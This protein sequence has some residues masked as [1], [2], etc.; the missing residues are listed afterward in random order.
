[1]TFILAFFQS[2]I[3]QYLTIRFEN[4]YNFF[5]D[6]N[7]KSHAIHT[8]P[9]PRVGGIG[10]FL[11]FAISMMIL[12]PQYWWLVVGG[13]VIFGFGLYEDWHG[14]TRKEFRLGAMA[15]GTYIAIYFGGYVADNSEFFILP[16]AAAAV[17]TIFAV[18][19]TSSAI[20]FIDGLNGLAGGLSGSVLIFFLGLAYWYGDF[21]L[22][23]VIAIL[24]GA[25]GGFFLWNYPK[26]K[27]FLGDGGAYFLGSM[28]A[29]IAIILAARHDEISLWYAC[30]ALLYPVIE[31]FVTIDRRINRKRKY[32]TPFFEA[33]RVHLHTLKFRRRTKDN[34]AATRR[35]LLFNFYINL[36]AVV[37][38]QSVPALIIV[39]I[40]AYIA[41]SV[42]YKKIIRFGYPKKNRC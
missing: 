28:L 33:E 4:K 15:V 11:A 37:F 38:H 36:A 16:Y 25:I 1:M 40:L 6:C 34:A 19:G 3:Y 31:T 13:A 30:I 5:V 42:K 21:E 10:I 35:I 14:D 22:V 27:I 29:M 41:Y 7:S 9:T 8:T 12:M 32:G 18:V 20:N 39:G 26:G 23:S 17:F 24:L 2:L